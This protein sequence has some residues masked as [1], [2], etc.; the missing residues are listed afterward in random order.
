MSNGKIKVEI[1]EG[2]PFSGCC[3]P[4]MASPSS[5]EKLRAMLVERNKTVEALKEEFKEQI[6]VER[7]IL[8]I[9]LL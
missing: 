2:D 6:E 3:G 8:R 7:D 5:A 9:R 1:Y 4:S